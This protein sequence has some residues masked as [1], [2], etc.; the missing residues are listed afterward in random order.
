[1]WESQAPRRP[2]GGCTGRA[3]TLRW[4][5][6]STPAV[7][8]RRAVSEIEARRWTGFTGRDPV[9]REV[10]NGQ[11]GARGVGVG[12]GDG[13]VTVAAEARAEAAR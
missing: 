8:R 10:D 6:G 5:G 13:A 9:R 7:S 2:G 3:T 4:G 12:V 11:G 1:M